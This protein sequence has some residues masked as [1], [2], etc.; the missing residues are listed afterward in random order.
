MK[1]FAVG[2]LC[3]VIGVGVIAAAPQ[4]RDP[5]EGWKLDALGYQTAILGLC[6]GNYDLYQNVLNNMGFQMSMLLDQGG[7]TYVWE[8]DKLPK[9]QQ[10]AFDR[11]RDQLMKNIKKTMDIIK[12]LEENDL[13]KIDESA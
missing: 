10:I 13:P 4:E 9:S 6:E 3:G 12:E 5:C 1:Q 7:K 8:H 2:L 11:L